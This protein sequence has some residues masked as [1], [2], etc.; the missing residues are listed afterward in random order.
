MLAG[1]LCKGVN[2]TSV[3]LTIGYQREHPLLDAEMTRRV[4]SSH[5][6]NNDYHDW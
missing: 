1:S 2:D 4:T 6:E 5:A 3:G